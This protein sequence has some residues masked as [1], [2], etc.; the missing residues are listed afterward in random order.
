MSV[1]RLTQS[2]TRH[3]IA[4]V[5]HFSRSLSSLLLKRE[6]RQTVEAPKATL[7]VDSEDVQARYK[8]M[9][10]YMRA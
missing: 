3:S 10:A 6:Y 8:L 7:H 2:S 4:D 1:A 9:F 5:P